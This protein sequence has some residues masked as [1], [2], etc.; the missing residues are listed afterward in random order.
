MLSAGLAG[1]GLLV[2]LAAAAPS[3]STLV[4]LLGAASAAGASVNAA[5][6]RAVMQW[7]ESR[8]AGSRSACGKRLCRWAAPQLL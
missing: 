8:S 5:S 1:M 6:G 2:A 7:F 3:F 4:L